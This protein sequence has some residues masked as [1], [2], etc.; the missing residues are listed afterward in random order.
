ME[1]SIVS[2]VCYVY[3]LLIVRGIGFKFFMLYVLYNVVFLL[4]CFVY[5]NW[6]LLVVIVVKI[7]ELFNLV[8]NFMCVWFVL[9]FYVYLCFLYRVDM[10][11]RLLDMD[12]CLYVK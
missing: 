9:E 3:L 11:F 10:Y 7:W 6:V 1:V 5:I 2:K 12:F 4:I 8:V